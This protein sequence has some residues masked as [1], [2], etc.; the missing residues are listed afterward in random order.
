[1]GDFATVFAYFEKCSLTWFER[2]LISELYPV[3]KQII[4]NFT[5]TRRGY[6]NWPRYN[7]GCRDRRTI[8]NYKEKIDRIVKVLDSSDEKRE[9]F[10]RNFPKWKIQRKQNIEKLRKIA[11]SMKD[12]R[13]VSNIAKITAGSVGL[14]GG[15]N[16]IFFKL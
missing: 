1:M 7:T 15:K 16:F 14:A 11:E 12:V 6:G 2:K 9:K 5:K 8:E 10:L 13:K 4:E 3:I